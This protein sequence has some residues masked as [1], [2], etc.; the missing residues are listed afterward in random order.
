MGRACPP[1]AGGDEVNPQPN[2]EWL[3]VFFGIV[4]SASILSCAFIL[5]NILSLLSKAQAQTESTQR[6]S[7][8]TPKQ[9][10]ET[11]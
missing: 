8:L 3:I 7:E 4:I 2:F 5:D 1:L 11:K 10:E 6:Q 9:S